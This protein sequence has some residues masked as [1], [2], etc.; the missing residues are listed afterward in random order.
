MSLIDRNQTFTIGWLGYFYG[1]CC[2]IEPQLR[3]IPIA[4]LSPCNFGR[5]RLFDSRTT[6]DFLSAG[7]WRND[8]RYPHAVFFFT[9]GGRV[10]RGGQKRWSS[11]CLFLHQMISWLPETYNPSETY[12]PSDPIKTGRNGDDKKGSF[13]P[14][15]PSMMDMMSFSSAAGRKRMAD[16]YIQLYDARAHSILYFKFLKRILERAGNP[17]FIETFAAFYARWSQLNGRAFG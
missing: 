16:H 4:S 6:N 15:L 17:H 1:L 10:M 3:G 11:I 12:V 9:S 7:G 14:L 5:D 13:D 8:I 2:I